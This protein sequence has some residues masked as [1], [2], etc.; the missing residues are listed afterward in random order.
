MTSRPGFHSRRAAAWVAL[1]ALA[2]A[3]SVTAR[4]APIRPG[5]HAPARASDT[6]VVRGAGFRGPENLAYDSVADCY[7]VAN[8]NG[9]PTARDGNG[10]VSR[11]GPDGRVRALRWIAGGRGGATLD[12]P[13]GI[14]IRGDTLAVAD[15]GAVRFFDRRT[16]RPLGAV[17][18][19]GLRL[20][21]LAYADD[22]SLW[23]TDVGPDR[24]VVHDSLRVDTT[25]DLDAVYHVTPGRPGGRVV[26]VARGLHLM[27]PDGISP[28]PGGGALVTTFGD[29]VLERVGPVDSSKIIIT[30]LPGGRV[31]G[32]RPAP[33]GGWLVSSWDA[34]A[35]YRWR[36]GEPL[37]PVLT[38][39]T[40][41]AGVAVDTRRNRLAVT[42]MQENTVTIVP[43]PPAR[44]P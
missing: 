24:H 19:P 6:V 15:L 25:R 8:V 10:Y 43:L 33:G 39:L 18:V 7:Y 37:L 27:R 40:S 38:G 29:S 3:G 12:G 44:R 34:K 17:A 32:L 36:V 21:D 31:D 1:P 26:T 16:G 42:S 11:V 14:A 28:W 13:M 22:G 5:A 30:R 41:P 20:N 9:Q 4:P 23:V 2:L 35:V